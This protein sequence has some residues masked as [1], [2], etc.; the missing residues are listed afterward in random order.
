MLSLKGI[1]VGFFVIIK[2]LVYSL[3]QGEKGMVSDVLCR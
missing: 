2:A 1:S 3:C